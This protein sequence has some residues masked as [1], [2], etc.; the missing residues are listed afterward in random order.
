MLP[1]DHLTSD[2]NN[3]MAGAPLFRK[4]VIAT[5][6]RPTAI[7]LVVAFARAT[8]WVKS[9]IW[10]E[11]VSGW[12][13]SERD[14]VLDRLRYTG[15]FLGT[16]HSPGGLIPHRRFFC[17]PN[18]DSDW[19]GRDT[20]NGGEGQLGRFHDT[21][22]LP[23]RISLNL[24]DSWIAHLPNVRSVVVGVLPTE[25]WNIYPHLVIPKCTLI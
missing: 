20:T 25:N 23:L 18:T 5:R 9:E 8:M 6:L 16:Y 4:F 12:T 15:S 14:D 7:N 10:L 24:C 17:T 1:A 2:D 3:W 22:G 19:L 13:V 21:T 11:K